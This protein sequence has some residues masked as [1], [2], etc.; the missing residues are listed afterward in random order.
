MRINTILIGIIMLLSTLPVA[1]SDCT[2][3]ISGNTNEDD[4]IDMQ[5]LTHTESTILEYGNQ[6]QL[7]DVNNDGRITTADSLIVL[8]MAVG[9][10]AP[11][12]ERA[13]VNADGK[14]NSLDALMIQMMTQKTQVCVNAPEIV[15]GA[16]N[17]T[18]DIHNVADLDS[19]QFDLTFDSSVVNVTAVHDG[20]V[21]G[22]PVPVVSWEF[23]DTNTIHVLF[24]PQGITGVGGSG[25]IA[26]IS[27]ETTGSQGDA[28]VLDISDGKLADTQGDEIP[29]VWIDCEVTIGEDTPV[30]R[31]HNINTGEFFSSIQDAIDDL[32]TLDG[33]TIEVGDG[34]YRENVKVIKSLTIR[35]ENG[36]A[37][38]VIQG[39]RGNQVVEITV[40][41][42]SISGFTVKRSPES[43]FGGEGIYLSANYCNVSD[44][45][46]SNNSIGICLYASSNNSISS[47][48][49]SNNEW[50]GI[51]LFCSSNN[52]LTG[53]SMFENGI[54]ISGNSPGDYTHE[55]DESNTV[56]GK[57]VYYWLDI[58]SGRIPDG[59]GQVILVNCKDILVEDQELNS[60][61]VGIEVAFSSNITIRNNNC[62]N[63]RDGGI[64]LYQ[65]CNNSISSNNCSNNRNDGV[66]LSESYN[67]SISSNNCSNSYGGIRLYSSS[68]N[69][70]S[71]NNCSNNKYDGIHF[72]HSNNNSISSN[73]CSSN[74]YDIR[75][76]SSSNNKLT[77]NS[78]SESGISIRSDLLSDY[79]HEIDESNTVNGKPVYYWLGV[80]GGSI[81]EMAGQVVLVNCKD[82]LVEDQELNNA[83]VGVDVVFSSN[84]AIRNNNC[85][86][87]RVDGI[88]L[89]SS[90]NNIISSNDCSKNLCGIQFSESCDNIV[91]GNNCSNNRGDGICLYESRG[92]VM[93]LNNFINNADNTNSCP[94]TNIWN[95]TSTINY[96]YEGRNYTN[97]LGNCWDDYEGSDS[98]NDGIGDSPYSIDSDRDNCPLMMPFEN[99]SV[100]TGNMAWVNVN[101]PEVISGSFNATI[102]IHHVADLDSGQFDLS[103][104]SRFV[105]V[106]GVNAGKIGG[107][108]VPIVNWRFMDADTIRVIFKLDG[109]SGVSGSG[110]VARIDFETTGLWGYAGVLDI[111]NGK[112]VDTR[113][114]EMPAVWNDC[115]VT[116]PVPVTVNAPE[117]VSGAFE[118]TIDV[119][120]V[121]DLDS[122]QFDLSFDSSVLYVEDVDAGSIDDTEALVFWSFRDADT[123]KVIFNL[124]GLNGV[125]GSGYV[126]RIDFEIKGLP[127]D[128]CVL[129][130]SNGLLVNNRAE[131]M[132][133]IWT[134]DEVT[135]GEYTPV[136]R[137]HNID[138]GEDFPFIQTAIDDPDTLDGHT[139]TVEDGVYREHVR[140]TK[141]LTLRSE[142]G[143]I[144]C[145]IQDAD[146]HVVEIT[147]DYVNISGFTVGGLPAS[148]FGRVGMYLN[149]SYCNVSD[150]DC[151]N[152]SIGIFL[153]DSSNDIISRNNCSNNSVGIRLTHS[154]NNI[155]SRNNCS[156]NY[157][158]IHFSHSSNNSISDNICSKN[159]DSAIHLRH[160]SNNRV[161]GNIM[162][163]GGISIRG[164]SLIDYTHEIDESNTVNGKPVYYW[165]DIESE[166][167]PDGAGQVMLVNCKDVLVE[168]QEL[169]NICVGI[170]VVFSSNITIRNNTCS[171]SQNI[172]I[173]I[174]HSSN[175]SI[176]GNNCLNSW[177]GIWLGDSSYSSISN[178]NCSNNCNGICLDDSS[179]IT[180]P[181]NDCSNNLYGIHLFSSSTNNS[182]SSNNCSN[183]SVGISLDGSSNNNV[184]INKCINNNLY[185]NYPYPSGIRLYRSCDNSISNNDCS[186]NF[187][188]ISFD[189]SS[190]NVIYLN[191][192][193]NNTDNIDY[194][195]PTTTNVWSSPPQL[196]YTYGGKTFTNYLGNYWDDYTG[197]DSDKDGIGDSPCCIDSDRDNY[198]L[199]MPFENYSVESEN[200]SEQRGY[201]R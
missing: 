172:G 157:G 142:N 73:N 15:S 189:D 99:Y 35:S 148:A 96:T 124:P 126:A 138:T 41:Y 60:A 153:D 115:E 14:V 51:C 2:L 156:N 167:I 89:H 121:T 76:H 186:N 26:T 104:D 183:N 120:N 28:C 22:E 196:N 43:P 199:M 161:S 24:N 108:T 173:Y 97:Y 149:A 137:V 32:D 164:D 74:K 7:G 72:S 152:N 158:G 141:S 49:C 57:P 145:V 191:N 68:N 139:I 25:Q 113:G 6:T 179:N 98:D 45:N 130:I 79:T 65:S 122:G 134:R 63:N 184:S 94:S 110:C 169:D 44:N 8:Q 140:V 102:D 171:N 106:A 1:A 30:N 192:F 37:N 163:E 86:N 50:S 29:A 62:S 13:D 92:N 177:A 55:I 9:S 200:I 5:N 12:L 114:E 36:S 77:G 127:G 70:I 78:M 119:E 101:A 66:R 10:V 182:I 116:V 198:P 83:N 111:S 118:V 46:C 125:S 71:K 195:S 59:T 147:A 53:N 31:V 185:G 197:S 17:V 190:N 165:L 151:S 23:L 27:F 34:V 61:N 193:I 33:H 82:I 21:G 170:D 131:K 146:D 155:I 144:N 95:S 47:N 178:N 132:P 162:H 188:G 67:N 135:I 180:I 19:G 181:S 90:S 105:N 174:S 38:C 107:T 112:F 16:F 129:D 58:E 103:F 168:N 42:V 176:S 48:N 85:S 64:H 3:E 123:I 80:N 69:S 84:I 133:A 117:Y 93:Y 187:C 75:L 201:D 39:A 166:R 154:S 136:N 11:D 143:S 109:A 18:I 194:L 150:N 160:S 40:D 56:N 52:R 159:R 175:S 4:T 128:S 87:N 88:R 91:S 54:V 20:N 100:P 81:P